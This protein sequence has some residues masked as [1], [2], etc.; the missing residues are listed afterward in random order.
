MR[1]CILLLAVCQLLLSSLSFSQSIRECKDV[2][3]G[4]FKIVDESSGTTILKRT[5]KFQTEINEQMRI[6]LVLEINWLD[7]CTYELKLI[8]VI[9]GDPAI[10]DNPAKLVTHITKVTKEGYQVESKMEGSDVVI[11]FDVVRVE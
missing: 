4:V 11:K 5:S 9:K 1:K 2:K 8:K 6:E 3:T 10:L 7:E